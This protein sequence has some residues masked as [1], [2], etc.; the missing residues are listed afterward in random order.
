MNIWAIKSIYVPQR[1]LER[2]ER[3]SIFLP[4]SC[5][6]CV[7]V[8]VGKGKGQ[9]KFQGETFGLKVLGLAKSPQKSRPGQ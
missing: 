7:C 3:G 4:I 9:L 2:K 8:C 5:V 1:L 6:S